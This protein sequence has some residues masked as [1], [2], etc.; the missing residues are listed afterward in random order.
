MYVLN[1]SWGAK[2]V[3]KFYDEDENMILFCVGNLVLYLKS[4]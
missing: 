1:A 4:F 3:G 2:K